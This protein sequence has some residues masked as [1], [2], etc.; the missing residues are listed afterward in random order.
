VCKAY[1]VRKAV[2][3][4]DLQFPELFAEGIRAWVLDEDMPVEYEELV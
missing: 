1:V 3:G 2:H 4:W